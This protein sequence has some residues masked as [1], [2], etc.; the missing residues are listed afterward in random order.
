M[1]C[2]SGTAGRDVC[3]TVTALLAELSLEIQVY[4]AEIG[5]FGVCLHLLGCKPLYVKSAERI[6][7]ALLWMFE[8]NWEGTV[9][10][11]FGAG[12]RGTCWAIFKDVQTL[13]QEMGDKKPED[14][15]C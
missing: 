6:C 2:F 10:N 3:D 5:C 7:T 8:R 1:L 14:S 15:V 9:G 12:G 4:I 11:S 13:T